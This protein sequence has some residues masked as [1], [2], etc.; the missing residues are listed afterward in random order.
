MRESSKVCYNSNFAEWF[1]KLCPFNNSQQVLTYKKLD[2]NGNEYNE[3]WNLG[4]KTKSNS[5][6]DVYI[7]ETHDTT[8]YNIDKTDPY[9]LVEGRIAKIYNYDLTS[10]KTYDTGLIINF[11]VEE[12]MGLENVKIDQY[13]HELQSFLKNNTDATIVPIQR[14]IIKLVNKHILLLDSPFPLSKIQQN[15]VFNLIKQKKGSEIN[16][17]F[18]LNIYDDYVYCY[19]CE[20]LTH[21]SIGDS[22]VIVK[23][24]NLEKWKI[25]RRF[26]KW[27]RWKNMG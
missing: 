8:S 3:S 5:E 24:H 6:E 17:S 13:N 25:F 20:F 26:K 21:Y 10:L 9:V 27:L 12:L 7:K 11:N 19:K 16:H 4:T 2:A 18:T 1:Y 22:L 14:K 23:F 15:V